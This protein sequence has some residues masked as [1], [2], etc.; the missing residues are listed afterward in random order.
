MI[1]KPTADGKTYYQI[2]WHGSG[3]IFDKFSMDAIGS[4]KNGAGDGYG[5]YL[6]LNRELAEAYATK[7]LYM[8]DVVSDCILRDALLFR[9]QHPFVQQSLLEIAANWS[10]VKCG[11]VS[12]EEILQRMTGRE[13]YGKLLSEIQVAHGETEITDE[14]HKLASEQLYE[15]GILGREVR[16]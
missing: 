7:A 4:A 6:A 12:A 11:E 15:Y 10:S 2:A 1:D 5:I 8:V 9:E 3:A 16:N 13:I 14:T